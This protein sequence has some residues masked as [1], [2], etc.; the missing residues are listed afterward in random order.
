LWTEATF[1]K[2]LTEI[3]ESLEEGGSGSIVK[4]LSKNGIA[5]I[6]V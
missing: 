4:G 2:D 3:F 1:D 5:A 6:V